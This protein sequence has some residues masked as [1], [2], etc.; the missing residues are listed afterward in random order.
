MANSSL[1]AARDAKND[2]FYTRIEDINEEMNHYEDKFHGKIVFCNCDDPKW[3]NFWKYFHLNFEYLGLKK[4]ITTHYEPGNVQTYK[5][6]YTGGDDEDF[7]KGTITPLTQNGDF[8]SPECLALLDEADIVVTNPPFSL[9]REYINILVEHNKQFLIIGNFNNITYKDVF[10]LIKDNKVWFGCRSLSK[11][12][13]FDVPE[14]RKEWLV[15]NK[16]KG[17]AYEIIDGIVMGRLASACWYTNIDHK[18][19][20]DILDTTYLYQK[21]DTLYPDLYPK[22]DNYD[23]INVDRIKEIPMDYNGVMGVPITYIGIH[24]PSQFE[25][26]GIA[27]SAR[28]IG[29]ECLTL[30]DN[31]KVYNRLLIRRKAGN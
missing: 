14:D 28:W 19:R 29:Y 8:R 15:K 10:P 27:N 5:I 2:E 20:H 26:L 23:I 21:K 7:E 1:H 3:S 17:S 9:F 31:K 12:M 6:E 4:L 22:Y 13:Y 16:K 25:I 18:K 24:N 30:L 11:E